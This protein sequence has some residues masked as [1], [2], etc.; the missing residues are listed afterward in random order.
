MTLKQMYLSV[1]PL[2]SL[3]RF[4]HQR[5]LAFLCGGPFWAIGPYPLN[6]TFSRGW[7]KMPL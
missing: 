5:A 2:D 6:F 4:E 1:L 7:A 3:L